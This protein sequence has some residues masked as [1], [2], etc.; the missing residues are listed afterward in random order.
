MEILCFQMKDR[1]QSGNSYIDVPYFPLPN[2]KTNRTQAHRSRVPTQR[3]KLKLK[4]GGGSVGQNKKKW[5]AGGLIYFHLNFYNNF[6]TFTTNPQDLHSASK[7]GA[8]ET[9]KLLKSN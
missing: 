3:L 9:W 6:V 7:T 5:V 4:K 8:T 1:L 2:W